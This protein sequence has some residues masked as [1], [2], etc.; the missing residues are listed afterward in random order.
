MLS[1]ETVFRSCFVGWLAGFLT[2][3]IGGLVSKP[4]EFPGL[5]DVFL[6]GFYSFLVTFGVGFPIGHLAC[7]II[8]KY[9]LEPTPPFGAA[10]GAF[11]GIGVLMIVATP[12]Y[13]LESVGIVIRFLLTPI[14]G[15]FFVVGG[16]TGLLIAIEHARHNKTRL[17]NPL[18]V[19]SRNEPPDSNL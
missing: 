13:G 7:R 11:S 9:N 10:I 1:I 19:P 4:N 16:V 18:H 8:T 14:V 5:L 12:F 3:V 6:L 15:A 17:D 2:L